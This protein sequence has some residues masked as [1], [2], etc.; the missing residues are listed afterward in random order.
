MVD[1]NM[2]VHQKVFRGAKKES[3]KKY[4]L[5]RKRRNTSLLKCDK[6]DFTTYSEKLM[7]QG[8]IV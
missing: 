1:H 6:G 8:P 5:R 4:G 3:G 7:Q 2:D